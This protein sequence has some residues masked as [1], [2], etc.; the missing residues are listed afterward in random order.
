MECL[1]PAE[2][3]E[4]DGNSN[5][6]SFGYTTWVNLWSGAFWPCCRGFVWVVLIKRV[7]A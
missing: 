2:V 6:S 1:W 4:W 7:N 3:L 5:G